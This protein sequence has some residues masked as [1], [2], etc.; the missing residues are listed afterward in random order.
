M[1]YETETVTGTSNKTYWLVGAGIVLAATVVTLFFAQ[2]Q[3]QASL[4]SLQPPHQ[5]ENVDTLEQVMLSNTS[6]VRD[7]VKLATV[8]QRNFSTQISAVGIL[9]V[10]EP[11]ERTIA[12]WAPGRIQ[13]LYIASTG[14]YVRAG[15]PLYD[16]YSPDILNA[17]R[18][19]LIAKNASQM[20][21]AD[22]TGMPGMSNH[23]NSTLIQA[24][25]E[26]LLLY[27]LSSEQIEHLSNASLS[28]K[29]VTIAASASG[30]VLQKATQEGAYVQEGTSIFQLADLSTVWAEV[31]VP[32]SEIRFIRL[33][34][35]ISIQTDAY[36]NQPFHGRVILI[37]PIVDQA[38]RTVR[39]R[40]ELSN[41]QGNLRP[42]MT[43]VS[44]IPIPLGTS[45]AVPEDAVIR[46]G[47]GDFVWVN[48]GGNMFTAHPVTLGAL[49]PDDYYQVVGGLTAG[50]EVAAQG[51]FLVDAEYQFTKNNPMAGMNMGETGTKNSGDGTATVRAINPVKQTITLD[52]GNI[53]GLMPAMSMGYKVSDRKFLQSVKVNE[54]VRFTLTRQSDGTFQITAIGPE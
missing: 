25:K 26:R 43:F 8:E 45:L 1:K 5:S 7:G 44:Q 53:P 18:E 6:I 41:A 34:E 19:Y 46:T 29:T 28:A 3:S 35:I 13:R 12:A 2:K 15:E 38:S 31:Q 30:I 54:S 9:E 17:E 48:N 20:T 23:S 49:S 16:F 27:G 21:G 24:A 50:D 51:A 11:G 42:G 14:E 37:S 36:P 33:G 52:N 4:V 47:K 32:E 40:L 22:G 39:V 10:P